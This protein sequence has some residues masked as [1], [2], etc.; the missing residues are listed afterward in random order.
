MIEHVTRPIP[1]LRQQPA[2]AS[3]RFVGG[4]EPAGFAQILKSQLNAVNELQ[5]SAEAEA[6]RLAR[7]DVENLHQAMIVAS[8]AQ[9]VLD[10]TVAIRNKVLEAYQE[11]SRMQL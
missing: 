2:P 10:L 9:V 8:K 3:P 7:G 5:L 11:I 6:R 1:P 4:D